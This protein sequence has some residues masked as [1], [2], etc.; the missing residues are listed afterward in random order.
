VVLWEGVLGNIVPGTRSLSIQQHVVSI[1]HWLAPTDVLLPAVSAT[2][3]L[4]M[5]SVFAVGFTWL[6][7]RRLKLFSVAG[8]T[9]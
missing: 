8:E 7:I 4:V 5:T 2:V 9:G 6:A 3:A 1:A